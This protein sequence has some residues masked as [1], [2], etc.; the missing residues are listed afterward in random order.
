MTGGGIYAVNKIA[1]SAEHR[2]NN[3]NS[4]SQ[5]PQYNSRDNGAP[6][7]QGYWG[8]PGPQP[9]GPPQVDARYVDY[10][11]QRQHNA[12]SNQNDARY[13]RG[14][15]AGDYQEERYAPVDGDYQY[16]SRQPIAPPSYYPQQG[17]VMEPQDQVYDQ[18]R[19][20]RSP[21]ADLAG[22]AMQFVGSGKDS[23]NKGKGLDKMSEF[24]KK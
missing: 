2:H 15:S 22:M 16:R 10:Q 1:K 23:G 6:A 8:P 21:V 5:N 11:D 7:N 13:A 17:H 18:N 12:G 19:G 9:R 14:F 3:N 4:S 20:R 24:F